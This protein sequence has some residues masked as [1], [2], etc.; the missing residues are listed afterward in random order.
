MVR[1][2]A[3]VL[4]EDDVR[5]L[6]K[7]NHALDAK[8]RVCC[9][10]VETSKGCRTK[11]DYDADLRL[12]RA[13]SLLPEGLSF[14]LDYGFIPSTL[15]DDGDPLDVMILAD[16]FNPPGSLVEIC[17]IA[18]LEIEEHEHN[19][20]ER[21]DRVLAISTL[22]HLYADVRSPDDL[23]SKFIDRLGAFWKQKAKLDGKKVKLLHVRD[24][25]TAVALVR[26]TSKIA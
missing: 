25:D 4:V 14:P 5:D 20:V 3:K 19:R 7:L 9:A 22:S 16:E 2:P 8:S 26:K 10:I 6:G 13:N 18:V 1:S 24:G 21:N 12:F 15:C 23:P 17:L 11:F